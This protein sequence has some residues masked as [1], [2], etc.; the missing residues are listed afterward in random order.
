M[1]VWGENRPPPHPGPLVGWELQGRAPGTTKIPV[2]II[3]LY[4]KTSQFTSWEEAK[5][6]QNLYAI[7]AQ[8]DCRQKCLCFWKCAFLKSNEFG[9]YEEVP[10]TI[11]KDLK[12]ATMAWASG[13]V[14]TDLAE[15]AQAWGSR[16]SCLGLLGGRCFMTG[17]LS[18]SGVGTSGPDVQMCILIC[19]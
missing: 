2:F 6:K 18:I 10:N 9:T 7:Q 5:S 8:V 15:W 17:S 4:L 19:Q 11:L 13:P 14:V 16:A 3:W 12:N 1:S